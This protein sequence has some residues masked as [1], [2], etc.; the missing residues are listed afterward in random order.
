MSKRTAESCH[1]LSI[2]WLKKVGYLPKEDQD[3]YGGIRWSNSFGEAGNI[4][5]TVQLEGNGRSC[6]RLIYTHTNH[7]TDEK[8]E[9]DYLVPLTKTSCHYGGTRYWFI[10]TLTVNGRY[11]GRRVGVLFSIGKYFGCRHCGT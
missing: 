3:K 10:C 1:N 9:M 7:W 8:A 2:F 5:F 4:N 11:C 6:I